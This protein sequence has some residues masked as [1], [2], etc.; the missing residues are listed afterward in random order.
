[1][2]MKEKGEQLG[3]TRQTQWGKRRWV[4]EGKPDK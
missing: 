2:Y 1:M 3:K 4:N